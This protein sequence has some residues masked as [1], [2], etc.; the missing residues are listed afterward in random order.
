MKK[1][2]L[3]LIITLCICF[4]MGCGN[5]IQTPKETEMKTEKET[6][7]L[8]FD[9]LEDITKITVISYGHKYS[10]EDEEELNRIVT[11]LK[12]VE[13]EPADYQG[14]LYGEA[15]IVD[16]YSG[17]EQIMSIGSDNDQNI[18]IG[19]VRYHR[20]SKKSKET[21]A[22]IFKSIWENYGEG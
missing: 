3:L 10:T 5:K 21:L 22:G 12:R 9:Q 20:V 16:F 19:D 11:Y 14:I 17:E 7:N 13:L 6:E 15:A 2:T 8:I 1:N 18:L 4:F